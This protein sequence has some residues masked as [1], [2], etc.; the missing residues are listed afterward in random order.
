ML[1][2]VQLPAQGSSHSLGL[3]N[4]PRKK[5]NLSGYKPSE[6]QRRSNR[7]MMADITGVSHVTLVKPPL[8]VKLGGA[9]SSWGPQ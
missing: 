7:D 2:P 8:K 1:S 9:I 4:G 6:E 3:S 5:K